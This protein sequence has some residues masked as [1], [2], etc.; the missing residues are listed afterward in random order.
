ML[1]VNYLEKAISRGKRIHLQDYV[2]I[3]QVIRHKFPKF[4]VSLT[5][6]NKASTIKRTTPPPKQPPQATKQLYRYQLEALAWMKELEERIAQGECWKFSTLVPWTVE[7]TSINIFFDTQKSLIYL[8]PYQNATV[9][10]K[11]GIFADE[12]GLGKT[13]VVASL[14][15]AHG[16]K[17]K[18]EILEINS[19][20]DEK[21]HFNSRATLILAPN[22]L[23]KQWI[24]EMQEFKP[25]LK[26]HLITT[27]AQHCKLTYGDFAK[28]DAIVVSFQFLKNDSYQNIVGKA[29][30]L[31]QFADRAHLVD[32]RLLELRRRKNPM[33][34]TS[35][36]FEN[37]IWRRLVVDEGHEILEDDT[38]NLPHQKK[39]YPTLLRHIKSTFRWYVTGTPFAQG[40]SNFQA[41]L[42]FLNFTSTEGDISDL[43]QN[44]YTSWALHDIIRQNMFWRNTKESI[45]DEYAVPD[46]VEELLL[47]DMSDVERGMYQKAQAAHDELRMR[48]LCCHMQVSSTDAAIIGPGKKTLDEVRVI[49]LGH[50][51]GEVEDCVKRIDHLTIESRKAAQQLDLPKLSA[52]LKRLAKA[53]L[54]RILMDIEH[55]RKAMAAAHAS[56]TYFESILPLISHST[57]DPCAVC[58]S[59]IDRL[60]IT[61]CAHL[62]CKLCIEQ[63]VAL[64]GK[65]PTCRRTIKSAQELTE[66]AGNEQKE[67]INTKHVLQTMISK[68]G[69]KM[70]HLMQYLLN[71]FE[72]DD[73]ARVI[74]FSQWDKMLHEIGTT[75][76]EN[77]ISNVYCKGNVH[78]K[79]KAISIFKG[80][81]P[82]KP[83]KKTPTT[84]TTSTS[85]STTSTNNNNNNNNNNSNDNNNNNNNTNT[86]NTENNTVNILDDEVRV[87]MLS[88]ENAA[89]GTNLTEA[90]HVILIDPVSGTAQHARDVEAQAIGRAHRQGQKKQLTVVRFIIKNTVEE[91]LYQRNH[92]SHNSTVPRT[93]NISTIMA[94]HPSLNRADSELLLAEHEN[95]ELNT[96]TTK[97]V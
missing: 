15:A 90:S 58:L 22:H 19:M 68:Y 55:E 76:T 53:S 87:M 47:L 39:F 17:Y 18:N 67:E 82:N 30:R 62:F 43:D 29:I 10:T 57:S 75:L 94:A 66:V 37:F 81:R 74:I 28:A 73:S 59:D 96:S 41:A 12:M 21:R 8:K 38:H 86:T 3:C 78:V 4:E 33:L 60:T 69:T 32:L 14:I 54:E 36:L 84:T 83:K 7:D 52:D 9:T 56:L 25:P 61:P 91:E 26:V 65:C 64:S 77:G 63:C 80:L 2:L 49:M 27:K 89:S 71:L 40:F 34:A 72:T 46:V 92:T 42:Q 88:L 20:E 24:Q 70:A 31:S 5:P 45:G 85:T 11:G 6:Y 79:N 23:C 16:I 48:Q 97:T 95:E 35:P 51:R 1:N 50:Q 44:K 93:N 13:L